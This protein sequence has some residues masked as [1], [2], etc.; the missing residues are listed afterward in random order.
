MFLPLYYHSVSDNV[1]DYVKH[2][3]PIRSKETF[4]NDLDFL[5]SKY[6]A[7]ALS[8]L[9]NVQPNSFLLTFDDGLKEC[10]WIADELERR[11]LP[12]IFFATKNFAQHKEV[13]Y[14]HQLSFLISEIEKRGTINRQQ[15]KSLL[16]VHD[17]DE[18]GRLAREYNV[19][20]DELIAK[21]IYMDTI[22]LQEL[23]N[24]GFII[25][26]HSVSHPH[27]AEIEEQQAL[28]E[29]IESIKWVK[30]AIQPSLLTF[31]FPYED[32]F[33]PKS[34]FTTI[35]TEC[36]DLSYTFGTS[37]GKTEVVPNH[38]QRI[39]AES[40]LPSINEVISRH[41]RN[42]IARRLLGKN[43]IRRK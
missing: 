6:S 28:N 39:N 4:C 33:L 10:L 2:L 32:Y 3:Y 12:A 31:A 7:L 19:N 29:S 20:L 11:G 16:A 13:F 18:V 1:P 43:L 24:R 17:K 38:I 42:K 37:A 36:S 15:K 35:K 22:E 40:E 21:D 8:Q 26:A 34:F 14:R 9:D 5:Q 30:E 41:K 25:G 23:S 27:F